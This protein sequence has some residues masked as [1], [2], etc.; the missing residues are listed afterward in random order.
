MKI[1][2]ISIFDQNFKELKNLNLIPVGLGDTKFSKKWL[3]DKNGKNISRKNMNFGE[4]TFHYNI[5]KNKKLNFKSNEWIGFC[6][7][8]RFWTKK[9]S[10]IN[11]LEELDKIILKKPKYNWKNY[12]VILGQPLIFGKIKNLKLIKANIFEVIKKPSVMFKKNT[13][14]DQFRIF[15]GSFFLDK[16]IE[17]MPKK[18]QKDFLK[19]L[20]GNKFYPFNMFICKNFKI[21]TKFYNEIFPWLFKCEK[22]FK[23][24]DLHGYNKARIYGFLAERFMPF[25]F[26]KNFK[27]TTCPITFF[28]IK[29]KLKIN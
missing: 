6:S 17:L 2:C 10:K 7:Y 26:I 14:E 4:Y 3:S 8:R 24:H 15:H 9:D 13:L 11:S 18:Y 25:W 29:S 28:D 20:N 19:Y 16:A 21:L 5:W 27:T 22:A 12:D 1:F 23:H